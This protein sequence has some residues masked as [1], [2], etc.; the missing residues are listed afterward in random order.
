M[1]LQS[2]L[3]LK[4]Y[5][6]MEGKNFLHLTNIWSDGILISTPLGSLGRNINLSGPIVYKSLDSITI[7]PISPL[8]LNFRPIILPSTAE[9]LIEVDEESRSPAQ[10]Y[11][12]GELIFSGLKGGKKL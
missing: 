12:D 9:L 11:A 8:S 10:V 7:V 4:I 3:K 6:K 5:A 1:M 2:V